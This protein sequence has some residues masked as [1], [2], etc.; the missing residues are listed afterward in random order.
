MVAGKALS[1]EMTSYHILHDGQEPDM[2]P[3]G[4]RAFWGK[5]EA[6]AKTPGQEG[7]WHVAETVIRS[8]SR[9]VKETGKV[10]EPVGETPLSL[11]RNLKALP[12]GSLMEVYLKSSRAHGWRLDCRERS[13][14]ANE[15]LLSGVWGGDH[16]V[17]YRGVGE[18]LKMEPAGLADGWTAKRRK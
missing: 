9:P 3:S 8:V 18:V 10:G 13:R 17:L 6:R 12:R 11:D 4:E 1:E 5:R 16:A 14:E 7:A 2:K 15:G